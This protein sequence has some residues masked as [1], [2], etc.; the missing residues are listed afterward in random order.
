MCFRDTAASPV[1]TPSER[2]ILEGD[3]TARTCIVLAAQMVMWAASY[4]NHKVEA[5]ALYILSA[6]GALSAA[7][8]VAN[9][10]A[11]R[12]SDGVFGSHNGA[13]IVMDTCVALAFAGLTIKS[14]SVFSRTQ[15]QANPR[16]VVLCLILLVLMLVIRHMCHTRSTQ[17]EYY[18]IWDG[19]LMKSEKLLMLSAMAV[20]TGSLTPM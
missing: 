15:N 1:I 3:Y 14:V 6:T 19:T 8:D 9:Y 18:R 7:V 12:A 4:N 2:R 17:V 20:L 13:E 5:F 11:N 10:M 16:N